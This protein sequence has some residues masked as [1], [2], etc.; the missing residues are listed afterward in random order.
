ML[1][2]AG[3]P[4]GRLYGLV[5]GSGH[6]TDCWTLKGN[7]GDGIVRVV[8]GDSKI[9]KACTLRGSVLTETASIA[10]WAVLGPA[11]STLWLC[12]PHH[13]GAVLA[14]GSPPMFTLY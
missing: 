1:R 13:R 14:H 7:T 11:P 4:C 2:I 6:S 5:I 9:P 12:H 3:H 10:L 8:T